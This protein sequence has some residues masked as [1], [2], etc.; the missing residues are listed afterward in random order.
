MGNALV[1]IVRTLFDLYLL[2]FVLRLLLQWARVEP[3]NPLAQFI[4]RVTNPVVLPLRRLLPAMGRVDTATVA[5]LFALQVVASGLLLRFGCAGEAG[6][7]Q[8]LGVAVL[9][10]VDL[11]LRV[12]FWTILIYVVLSWVGQGGGNPAARLVGTLARPLLRPFQRL[13]PPVA[14]FDLSPL[15]AAIALQA[16]RMVL[17][18]QQV[19]GGL[20]CGGLAGPVL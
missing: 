9:A 1:F 10:L 18:V 13:I 6:A 12:A 2:T 15:F 7:L 14:G 8:V 4:Q 20:A 16:L 19:L 5:A 11:F 17:P 3:W